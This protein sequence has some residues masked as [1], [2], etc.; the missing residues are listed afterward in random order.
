MI[1]TAAEFMARLLFDSLFTPTTRWIQEFHTDMCWKQQKQ[2][3]DEYEGKLAMLSFNYT[4]RRQ[5]PINTSIC[6]DHEGQTLET[7]RRAY[8]SHD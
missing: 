8:F 4:R 2:R 5:F 6:S 3:E 1:L 7:L